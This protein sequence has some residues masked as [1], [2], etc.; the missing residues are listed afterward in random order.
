[1]H[2]FRWLINLSVTNASMCISSKHLGRCADGLQS[3][4]VQR[5]SKYAYWCQGSKSSAGW[6]TALTALAHKFVGFLDQQ[7]RLLQHQGVLCNTKSP[8]RRGQDTRCNQLLAL[9]AGEEECDHRS[10]CFATLV[11]H[12]S[13][14]YCSKVQTIQPPLTEVSQ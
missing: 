10:A 1:M 2:S 4:A 13:H 7:R 12:T 6:H 3:L 5:Q 8:Y 9:E 14:P 11:R